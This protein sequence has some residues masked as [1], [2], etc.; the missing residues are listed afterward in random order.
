MTRLDYKKTDNDTYQ[1]DDSNVVSY[2]NER[3]LNWVA[4]E[5][6]KEDYNLQWLQ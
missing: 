4:L 2:F 5:Y 3:R 1:V 6:E